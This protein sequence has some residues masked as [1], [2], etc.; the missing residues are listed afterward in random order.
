[1]NPI[2][3]FPHIPDG[4]ALRTQGRLEYKGIEFGDLEE[5]RE[6]QKNA[7]FRSAM[8]ISNGTLYDASDIEQAIADAQSVAE[9]T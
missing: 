2:L 5:L 1:M 6:Y 8:I 4:P 9:S 7:G 3:L